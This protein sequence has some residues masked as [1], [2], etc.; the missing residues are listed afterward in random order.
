MDPG[1]NWRKPGFEQGGPHPVTCVS[2]NDAM[3]YGQWLSDQTGQRYRLPTEA[4]WEYAARAGTPTAY[5]W[6]N[7]PSEGCAYA[8]GADQTAKQQLP[9]DWTVMECRDG[10]VYTAPVGRFRANAFGLY[11]MSGN[12]WEWT[13]SGYDEG[14]GGAEQRCVSDAGSGGPRVLRGGSW[15][16]LPR[17]LR[18][19]ARFWFA[20]DN[21]DTNA[22]FRL[23][24]TFPF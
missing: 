21:R 19:A 23:A 18:A 1:K 8:N 9:P 2:W 16:T 22:G 3:A 13:C 15:F 24:R 4:E 20:S 5:Y 14:Y 7:N 12:V 10:Y 11:D 17:R 6:G